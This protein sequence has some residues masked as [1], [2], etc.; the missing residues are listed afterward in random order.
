MFTETPEIILAISN[1][2]FLIFISLRL[3]RICY[4]SLEAIDET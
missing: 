4:L 3:L 1:D 2:D